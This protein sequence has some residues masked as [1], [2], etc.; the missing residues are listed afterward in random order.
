MNSGLQQ[1]LH[2]N[3]FKEST[4]HTDFQV[5]EVASKIPHGRQSIEFWFDKEVQ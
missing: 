5:W 4:E 2:E 3:R 1:F